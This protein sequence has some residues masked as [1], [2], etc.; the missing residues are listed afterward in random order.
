MKNYLSP[1]FSFFDAST[2][3]LFGPI[4]KELSPNHADVF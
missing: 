3:G 4:K 2:N 1:S